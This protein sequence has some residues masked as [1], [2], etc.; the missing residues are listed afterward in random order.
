M[1]R[2]SLAELETRCQKADYRRIGNWMA[3]RVA[4]PLALRVTWIVLPWG[5]SA[6]AVTLVAFLTGLAA[7]AG[8]AQGGIGGWLLGAA[9]LQLWYLL[10]H[11]DGQLARYHGTASLDG[12]ALDYLMHHVLGLC[13]PLGI[14]YG[15]FAGSFEPLWLLAGV[16]WGVGTLGIG[17]VNDVRYKAFIQRLKIVDGQLEVVGGGGARSLPAPAVP[18][19]LRPLASWLA[20]KLC[21]PHVAMNLL[22]AVALFAWLV[23][24]TRLWLGCVYVAGMALLA[25][26]VASVQL[27]RSLRQGATESEFKAWFRVPDDT[28]LTYRGDRWVAEKQPTPAMVDRDTPAPAPD[29][30]G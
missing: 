18:R 24:D 28:A 14:G 25:P 4:R 6:H 13:L 26:V 30:R 10:D 21:E 29:R 3:R 16:A 23:E 15:L 20:R 2:P 17:L 11:V 12:V 5:I 8:F 19:S 22:G 27:L 1:R 7:A 9:L